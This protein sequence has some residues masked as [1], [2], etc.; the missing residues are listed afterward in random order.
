MSRVLGSH[1]IPPALLCLVWA[2][3]EE[4]QEKTAAGLMEGYQ[5]GMT[6]GAQGSQGEAEEVRP[7]ILGS[8]RHYNKAAKTL[9]MIFEKSWHSG[10]DLGHWKNENIE[11]VLKKGK[12]GDP[13]NYQPVGLTSVPGQIM[14]RILLGAV[15]RHREHREVIQYN[16]HSFTKGK[17]CLTNQ[18]AF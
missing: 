2:P 10:K 6:L 8:A 7:V 16:Q 4:G 9:S 11:P 18:V 15:L 13:G 5:N 3:D 1:E 17:S 14:E 12:K